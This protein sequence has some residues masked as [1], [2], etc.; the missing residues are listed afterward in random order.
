MNRLYSSDADLTMVQRTPGIG[1]PARLQFMCGHRANREPG[2]V[3]RNRVPWRCAA[4]NSVR[5]AGE[6]KAVAA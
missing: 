4:C 6:E 3:F 2:A 5:V 1:V